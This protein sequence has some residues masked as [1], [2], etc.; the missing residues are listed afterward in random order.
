MH[1]MGKVLLMKIWID[2]Q[3][4]EAKEGSSVLEAALEAGIFIPHIC[5]HPDLE[6]AGGCRLCVVEKDGKVLPSCQM[7]VEEGL[8]VSLRSEKAKEVRNMAMEL[9]LAT[10]PPDCTGCPKY[11]KCE[12]QSMYQYMGVSPEKW[13]LRTR[14][15]PTDTSNPLITHMF[16]RCIRCARCIRACRGLREVNRAYGGNW[17]E[18]PGRS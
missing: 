3:Q 2:Q 14:S 1:G 9:I 10:H 18:C 12:L 7:E 15:V 5:K 16:T 8:K 4:I 6:A 11:G 17:R 13:R